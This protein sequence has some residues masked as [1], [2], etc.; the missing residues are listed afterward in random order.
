MADQERAGSRSENGEGKNRG[1]LAAV[2]FFGAVCIH[3]LEH[4]FNSGAAGPRDW[5]TSIPVYSMRE[6]PGISRSKICGLSVGMCRREV[7]EG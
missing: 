3:Y 7:R 4:G 5:L 6:R 1:Q 2:I